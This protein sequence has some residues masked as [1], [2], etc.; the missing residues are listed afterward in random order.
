[1]QRNAEAFIPR[2]LAPSQHGGV[3]A[4]DFG[5]S[6]SLGRCPVKV[7]QHQRG[8]RMDTV[9][10]AGRQHKHQERVLLGR[11]QA[12]LR[13]RAEQQRPDVHGRAGAVRGHELGVQADGQVD[14]LPE[15]LDGDLRHGDEGGRVLH[16]LRVLPRPED[17]DGAVVGGAEGLEA[18]VALLA[19]VQ[20]G[21]HAVQAQEGVLDE[22]GRG[23]LSGGLGVVAFDVAVDL[24]DAEAD[25]V[26]V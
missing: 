4:A 7:L 6:R 19:V 12:Q 25:V 11:T 9:V 26:P 21:R 2:L 20:A 17:V 10:D 24:A 16:A 22:L 15:Q 14:A 13:R 3:V 1:M 18:L 5:R 23:P 8:D